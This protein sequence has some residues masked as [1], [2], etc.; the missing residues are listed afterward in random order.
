MTIIILRYIKLSGSD[1]VDKTSEHEFRTLRER[2]KTLKKSAVKPI[3]FIIA[4]GK[5]VM[6]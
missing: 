6:P 4:R 2:R 3:I 1:F 5:A